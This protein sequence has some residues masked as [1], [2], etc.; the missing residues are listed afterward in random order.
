MF[1][2]RISVVA[3][4]SPE[5]CI[6]GI[7][8]R[9]FENPDSDGGHDG[10]DDTGDGAHFRHNGGHGAQDSNTAALHEEVNGV[11]EYVDT[12]DNKH[13]ECGRED[14]VGGPGSWRVFCAVVL[15]ERKGH[16]NNYDDG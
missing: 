13:N 14:G 15:C 3:T 5:I 6:V 1:R 2:S 8:V 16:Y 7:D 9:E 4:R 12:G 11:H 10:S